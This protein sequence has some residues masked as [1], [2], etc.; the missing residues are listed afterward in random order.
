MY[1]YAAEEVIGRS[2][3]LLHPQSQP[4]E[5]SQL[6]EKLERGE[7]V[8]QYETIRVRKDGTQVQVSVTLS[9]IKDETGNITGVA[10]V[11]SDITARKRAETELQRQREDVAGRLHDSVAQSLTALSMHA[12]LATSQLEDNPATLKESLHKMKQILKAEQ[13]DL[14]VF[15]H[16]LKGTFRADRGDNPNVMTVLQ[17]RIERL[18]NQWGL[19][20]ESRIDERVQFLSGALVENIGFMIQEGVANAARH[21]HASSINIATTFSEAA[22]FLSIVDNGRGFPFRGEYDDA[23]L[24]AHGIGPMML[25]SR[26][27]TLGGSVTL[28]SGNCGACLE[29]SL[30]SPLRSVHVD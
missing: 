23:L 8:V 25:R 29:I 17:N 1:G 7:P 10:S 15:L 26:V 2:I 11:S 21:G 6:R 30:P 13:R 14:R 20:I 3:S 12:E 27:A 28:R 19:S 5:L 9:P 16:E 24:T 4:N 18:E 22:L